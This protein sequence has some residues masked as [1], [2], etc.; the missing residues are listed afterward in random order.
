M[1]SQV[2]LRK[3]TLEPDGALEGH[4]SAGAFHLATDCGL[5]ADLERR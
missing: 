3:D 4:P 2:L 1:E 5:E